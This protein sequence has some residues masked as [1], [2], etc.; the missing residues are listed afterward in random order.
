MNIRAIIKEKILITISRLVSRLTGLLPGSL[1][2]VISRFLPEPAVYSV[3][4]FDLLS[5]A[6][7][8]GSLKNILRILLLHINICTAS[9]YY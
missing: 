5:D 9:Y 6:D 1:F 2:L 4:V 3:E 7:S 8:F